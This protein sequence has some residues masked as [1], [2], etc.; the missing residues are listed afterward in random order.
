MT[1]ATCVRLLNSQRIDE[2]PPRAPVTGATSER[3]TDAADREYRPGTARRSLAVLDVDPTGTPVPRFSV[4]GSPPFAATSAGD[5]VMIAYLETGTT[6][7]YY[8]HPVGYPQ[9]ERP[10]GIRFDGDGRMVWERA[11][12]VGRLT[13]VYALAPTADG[14]FVVH[15]ESR[16]LVERG[17]A[18]EPVA[19]GACGGTI[20]G[21]ACRPPRRSHPSAS[22]AGGGGV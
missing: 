17:S 13:R 3:A 16:R 15:G 22:R 19:Q 20:G 12:E 1:G 5:L 10:L 6:D 11:L 4:R 9:P 21:R 2:S 18:P 8:D 14:G 7:S